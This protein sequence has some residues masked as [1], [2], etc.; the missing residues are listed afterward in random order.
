[1]LTSLGEFLETLQL[2]LNSM[3]TAMQLNLADFAAD[4]QLGLSSSSTMSTVAFNVFAG[5]WIQYLGNM[6]VA[7]G[8]FMVSLNTFLSAVADAL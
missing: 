1:M 8:N 6:A 5:P 7:L 2:P 3:G 4:P